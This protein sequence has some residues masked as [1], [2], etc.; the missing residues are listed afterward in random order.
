MTDKRAVELIVAGGVVVTVDRERRVLADG[1]VAIEAGRIVAVGPTAEVEATCRP[2]R[3]IDAGGHIVMPGLVDAHVHITAETLT[4]GLALDDAGHRWMWDYALPLYAAITEDEEFVGASV[5][6]LEMLRNG[7]TTFA[8]G[9]TARAIGASARAVEASGQRAVLSPW[10]WDLMRDLDGLRFDTDTALKRNADAIAAHHGGAGGRLAVAT[11]CVTPGLCSPELLTGLKAL[12][13]AHGTTFTFHHAS[14][15]EPVDAY[16]AK[17]GRRPL[18]DYAELGILGRN[19]RTTHM[20]HLDDDEMAALVASGA[21]VAH[22][23]QTAFR[24][25]YGAARH[26]RFP[27]MLAQGVAVGLGTDGVNSS[28]NQ[29]LFKAMQIA[30]GL[31]KDA[32]QAPEL[33][34]AET[35]V[36]MA[37][38][39]GARALGMAG[40]IGS[41]E[42]GKRADMILID[43]RV[44]ELT[45]LIDVA[46]ALVYATDGRNVKTVIVGGR[47]LMRD[48]EVLTLD[49]ERL[50]DEVE[51]RAPELIA[52]AGLTPRPRW[53][54]RR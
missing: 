28:D 24:L 19:T 47:E 50:L 4:R 38:I 25:A 45:P 39:T 31:F 21:S 51:R 27:E 20:V 9:G 5:A 26:G 30:A 17:H 34:P 32:R 3:R 16:V 12:A 29:D 14:S 42:A 13:D 1:A 10:T 18:L 36:E 15:V 6:C 46:N 44:P 40:E 33:M 43:R 7:T 22:C 52:R 2:A 35:V 54:L 8:E 37:T 53:P 11:S 48:G 49:A 23:P 41:L